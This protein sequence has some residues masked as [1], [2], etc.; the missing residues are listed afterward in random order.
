MKLS[1]L[2]ILD[3]FILDVYGDVRYML[4]DNNNTYCKCTY[5]YRGCCCKIYL[6][7]YTEVIP[8]NLFM[9]I[10]QI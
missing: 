5:I 2:N 10:V 6:P 1:S 8:A 7:A 4:T 3:Y 9:D